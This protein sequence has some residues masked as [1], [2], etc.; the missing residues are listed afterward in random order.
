MKFKNLALIALVST[1]FGA[2]GPQSHPAAMAVGFFTPSLNCNLTTVNPAG[3][4][5]TLQSSSVLD[6]D[7]G[8]HMTLSSGNYSAN[9]YIENGGPFSID[10]NDNSSGRES[11]IL[12]SESAVRSNKTTTRLRITGAGDWVSVDCQVN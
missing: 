11:G 2:F 1:A 12:T 6:S 5:Q 3:Q 4:S 7:G 8:N 9:I 10:L